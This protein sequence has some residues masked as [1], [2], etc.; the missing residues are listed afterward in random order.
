MFDS[1]VDQKAHW[2]LGEVVMWIRTRD[3]EW[4]AAISELSETEAMVRAMFA[5]KTP[6]DPRS[7]SRFSTMSSDDDR[8]V[9]TPAGNN[10]CVRIEGRRAA[11]QPWMICKGSFGAVVFK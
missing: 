8:N 7:L 2:G 4:L 9:A 11:T 1:T 3:Y 6:L 5:L 10:Q